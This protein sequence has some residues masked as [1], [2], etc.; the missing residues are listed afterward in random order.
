MLLSQNKIAGVS[1][2]LAVSIRGGASAQAIARRLER[3]ISGALK[4]HGK[5]TDK[6]Y[7]T[8]FLIKA[9][10]GPRLLYALQKAEAYPS[11]T[12][13]RRRKLIP[14]VTVSTGVP[15]NVDFSDNISALLGEK[16]RHPQN[17][18]KIGV[19]VLI[20]GAAI[21]RVIRFNFKRRC[22][23]GIC[24]EHSE[25]IKKV[26][27]DIK[28]IKNVANAIDKDKICHYGKD[29]TVLGIAPVTGKENYHVTPLV[30]SASCKTEKGDQLAQWVGNFIQVYRDHP[31][32][33]MRHGPICTIC[34]DGESSFRRLRF[35]LGLKETI[36]KTSPLGSKLAKLELPGL[37]LQTGLF[38]VLG[39]CDP[40]HIIKR[41]ATMLR[42]PKG[43]QVGDTHITSGDTLRA[44]EKLAR[45]TPEKAAL[46]LNPIDKQ[47]V[48]KAVNLIQE[49]FDL[50]NTNISGAPALITHIRSVTFIADV[51]SHFLFPFTNVTQSLSE[52]ILSL[53]TYSHLITALYKKHALEFMTSALFADSQAIVKNI[54]FTVARLQLVDPNIDYHILFEGTDRL[55]NV[56]SHVRTQ[57]HARN[58]DIQQLSQKLSIAAEIDA[59]FQR[60][61]DLDRGHIR[62]NLV[63]AQGVDHMNP[64]SWT[65][66]VRVGDVDIKA[67]YMAGQK[68]ANEILVAHFSTPNAAIDFN[69]LFSHPEIDHLRPN[70]IYIGSS[71]GDEEED[72][73]TEWDGPTGGLCPD[74]SDSDSDIQ[75]V[76]DS[77]EIEEFNGVDIEPTELNPAL[78]RNNQHYLT[79][80]GVRQYIPTIVKNLL[81]ADQEQKAL[82]TTRSLRVQG[83]TLEQALNRNIL[84][85][86]TDDPDISDEKLK[87]GDLGAILVRIGDAICL[88]VAEVLNFRQ[89]SSKQNL[90]E[91]DIDDLNKD[92]TKVTSIAVQILRL[93]AHKAQP[94]GND[95]EFTW[96]WP[97]SYVQIHD[98]KSGPILQQ[99]F[100]TR[101][102]GGNFQ[103]LSPNIIYN[104]VQ[105]PVWSIDNSDLEGALDDAW[106]DLNPDS[107]DLLENINLLPEIFGPGLNQLP[108]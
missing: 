22:L 44:L 29:A 92:G 35:I 42:S 56:F 70:K 79:V 6:E 66:N 45:M 41:F 91:V 86:P 53:S 2:I 8:A 23:I 46:L 63:N 21:E 34:T 90:A 12:S 31:D 103:P 95:N 100:V 49:L 33:E 14:E 38:G 57:D 87:A 78:E 107:D 84:N 105:H 98:N 106:N 15:N 40:K 16:G 11:L 102:P 48:P 101:I 18:P 9:I 82:I 85:S 3:A 37:N 50:Q 52:Q 71:V 58:F 89:G 51:L 13:L 81:G 65:G 93:V 73:D 80:N 74:P 10:G 72:G 43:I 61:P 77:I 27:D 99:H 55:E 25:D 94:D 24:R 32:G 4:P 69:Q 28:D 64:K 20:D 26:V 104:S 1:R 108:Y 88:A 30:L 60:Y 75:D 17:N 19:N 54:I 76:R 68:K 39:T 47:N 97:E 62:R 36:D 7:D 83:V 96:W 59:I 67:Q 5:W